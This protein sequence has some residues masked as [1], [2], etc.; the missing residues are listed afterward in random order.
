MKIKTK[1][2]LFTSVTVLFSIVAISIYSIFDFRKKTLE[3][4]VLYKDEQISIIK[5][6]LKDNVDNAYDMLK[7]AHELA[8]A[9]IDP[10]DLR[11]DD[12]TDAISKSQFLFLTKEN[13]SNLTKFLK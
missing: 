12:I 13:T 4:I 5:E 7:Q 10:G 8:L 6:Q 11:N 1:L 9:S 2:P 3:S